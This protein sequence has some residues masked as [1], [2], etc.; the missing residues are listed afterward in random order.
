MAEKRGRTEVEPGA[1]GEK[2]SITLQTSITQFM[3]KKRKTEIH[4]RDPRK[5]KHCADTHRTQTQRVKQKHSMETDTERDTGTDEL[6][7]TQD[8][9]Q[10]KMDR[11]GIG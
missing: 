9:K 7:T 5:R 1:G 6:T 8:I 3:N 2:Q 10:R 4:K 11:T